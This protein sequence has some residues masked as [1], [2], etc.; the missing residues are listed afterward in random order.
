MEKRVFYYSF[1]ELYDASQNPQGEAGVLAVEL[2][3]YYG[4]EPILAFTIVNNAP[5]GASPIIFHVDDEKNAIFQILKQK[6][7]DYDDY[8]VAVEETIEKD[9]IG[10]IIYD[11]Y[12]TAIAIGSII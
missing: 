1:E 9:M 10:I 5:Q 11:G 12:D 4:F 2:L 3:K 6:I 8:Y 7:E